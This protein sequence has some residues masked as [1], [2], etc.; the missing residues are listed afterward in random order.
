LLDDDG[1]KVD[2]N[3]VGEIVVKSKYL[4]AG[5]WN[6]PDLTEAKFKIDARDP[7]KRL[8][9]TGD[10]GS[11]LAEGCLIH[12][13][14]KDFRVKIRGYGVELVE[15]EKVLRGH[16]DI[17]EA[18]VVALKSGTGEDRLAAYFTTAR[19]RPAPSVGGLHSYLKERLPDYMIPSVYVGLDAIPLTSNG[20]I[21]RASLPLPGK[22]RP[23]LDTDYAAP[24]NPVERDLADIWAELL[25]LD[26]VGVHDDFFA[27]GGHS[28][29]AARVISRVREVYD[30]ELSL[31]SL[32][33]APTVAKLAAQLLD[34]RTRMSA[35]ED[36]L[37][38]LA[39]VES[40]S[41][42]QALNLLNKARSES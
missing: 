29:L 25:S 32:F 34:V 35:V 15:V 13:G 22:G 18:V 7:E 24:K 30:V 19:A 23:E 38:V 42:Q 9:Y 41:E 26:R 14:R 2:F 12:K 5:Y 6:R 16:G 40:I 36:A 3:Q 21:D 4:A 11:M 28:L 8:Y 39:E 1:G 10:L 31:P 27:L 37:S 20:K 17:Q 33:A